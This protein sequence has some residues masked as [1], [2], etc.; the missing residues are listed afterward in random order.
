MLDDGVH[1]IGDTKPVRPVMVR[2]AA[3]VLLD[4]EREADEA[5][6]VEA[7]QA[8]EVDEH[9]DGVAHLRHVLKIHGAEVVAAGTPEFKISFYEW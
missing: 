5:V 1:G 4:S 9:V 6:L 8:K 2:D 7:C 3:V